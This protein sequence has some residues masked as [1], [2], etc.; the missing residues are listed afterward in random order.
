[1]HSVQM[2]WLKMK[3]LAKHGPIL[4][5]I[6]HKALLGMLKMRAFRMRVDIIAL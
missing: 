4:W 6:I 3:V 2:F 5:I 1:M